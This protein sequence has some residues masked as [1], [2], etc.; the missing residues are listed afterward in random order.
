MT[1]RVLGFNG[2]HQSEHLPEVQEEVVVS[3]RSGK[4]VIGMESTVSA[5]LEADKTASIPSREVFRSR[6]LAGRDF[7][8]P[9]LPTPSESIRV[10]W[11]DGEVEL[12]VIYR[13]NPNRYGRADLEDGPRSKF[14]WS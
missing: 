11:E 1:R 9:A 12:P 5:G 10:D 4:P 7:V 13:T 2:H 14:S 3:A 6:E 8:P